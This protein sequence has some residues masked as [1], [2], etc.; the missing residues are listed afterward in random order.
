LPDPLPPLLLNKEHQEDLEKLI[1]YDEEYVKKKT[2]NIPTSMTTIKPGLTPEDLQLV[3]KSEEDFDYDPEVIARSDI[4]AVTR[5]M[6]A[7]DKLSEWKR[8]QSQL[9]GKIHDQPTFED[10]GIKSRVFCLK[11][12]RELLSK[13]IPNKDKDDNE[14]N[15]VKEDQKDTN[16]D[17][18]NDNAMKS[19]EE[20]DAGKSNSE[21]EVKAVEEF[22]NK[23]ALSLEPVPSFHDQDYHRCLMIHSDLLTHSLKDNARKSIAQATLE[24]N[25]A[26]RLSSEYQTTKLKLESEQK[27]ALLD[28]RVKLELWT[29]T[30]RMAYAKWENEKK[31]FEAQ[32]LARKRLEYQSM[33]KVFTQEHS[34]AMQM[35]NTSIIRRALKGAV[36]RVVIRTAPKEQ[37]RGTEYTSAMAESSNPM[38]AQIATSLAHCVDVVVNRAETGWISNAVLDKAK[39]DTYPPFEYPNNPR[40]DIVL[41]EKG[42]NLEKLQARI[43]VQL[44]KISKHLAT[45]ESVRSQKWS[46]LM[47]AKQEADG[48]SGGAT[49]QAPQRKTYTTNRVQPVV[50]N[51]NVAMG[52]AA[53]TYSQMNTG[54]KPMAGGGVHQNP[55]PSSDSKYSAENVKARMSADGSVRPINMP[56]QT[57][58]GF[59]MRPAGRQ[60]KG[61]DWDAV[62]GKWVPQ[63]SLMSHR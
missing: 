42:E 22:M 13:E 45:C 61:M 59:F 14:D 63:G 12:R 11:E 10:L 24:Y 38:K 55:R 8:W 1:E 39:S 26:F 62:N 30:R 20:S 54:S 43:A 49:T 33:G 31:I 53:M 37:A 41:N 57:K 15:D 17:S 2:T 35:D 18:D 50:V 21:K 16:S 6:S 28:Y 58:D 25:D 44:E 32:Q 40:T 36:D 48:S 52:R 19:E 46:K 47:K 29:T 4:G 3:E 56:K 23:K 5:G 27:K 7:K 9:L 60:R 51:N 34:R